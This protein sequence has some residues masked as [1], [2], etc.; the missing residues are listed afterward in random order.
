MNSSEIAQRLDEIE[1][2]LV[3]VAAEKCAV[4]VPAWVLDSWDES[5]RNEKC[6]LSL[7]SKPPSDDEVEAA[8]VAWGEYVQKRG[9]ISGKRQHRN[10]MRAA[11]TAA[12]AIRRGA[13]T[14]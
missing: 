1:T 2:E 12:W 3:I 6:L 9:G 4:S 14:E 8:Y 10:A 11:L 5:L 13:K 7:L